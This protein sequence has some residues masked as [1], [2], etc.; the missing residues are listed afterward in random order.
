MAIEPLRSEER[1]F[2]VNDYRIS[3][4]TNDNYKTHLKELAEQATPYKAK[5]IAVQIS[6]EKEK[7]FKDN[8]IPY[9][10]N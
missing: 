1:M 10:I 4:A 9:T 7:W 5:Q 3:R 6:P 8:G 2:S